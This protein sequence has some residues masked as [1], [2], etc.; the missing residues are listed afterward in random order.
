MI[1]SELDVMPDTP[2][3]HTCSYAQ[4]RCQAQALGLLGGLS[5]VRL[6]V[7]AAVLLLR[8]IFW[9]VTMCSEVSVFRRFEGTYSL[10][11][12]SWGIKKECQTAEMCGQT[13]VCWSGW[14]DLGISNQSGPHRPI[15]SRPEIS[16]L[17]RY[18]FLP[19]TPDER[20]APPPID[21]PLFPNLSTARP[22]YTH[23]YALVCRV[24]SSSWTP[25]PLKM[26]ALCCFETSESSNLATRRHMPE[27]LNP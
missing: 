4:S 17:A 6:A 3:A 5:R 18:G 15:R 11:Y 16:S 9:G 2:R 10:H 25:R 26:K 23:T 20:T 12:H 19:S 1:A 7:S 8:G 13:W 14:W 22:T 24:W 27:D 21:S